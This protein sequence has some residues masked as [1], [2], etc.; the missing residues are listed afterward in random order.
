M[1][2][3]ENRAFEVCFAAMPGKRCAPKPL[4]G[5]YDAR[6]N[7]VVGGIESARDR[8]AQVVRMNRCSGDQNALGDFNKKTYTR[9]MPATHEESS[10]V[11]RAERHCVSRGS[12]LEVARTG[13]QRC[14]D[15]YDCN[16]G[17]FSYVK[18]F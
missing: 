7:H 4:A 3:N 9:L 8:G 14:P 15:G 12:S 6:G 10:R 2:Q 13:H 1:T 11:Q 16:A 18:E 17:G 5:Y